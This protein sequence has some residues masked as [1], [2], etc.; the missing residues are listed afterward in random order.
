M[1]FARHAILALLLTSIVG[2]HTAWADPCG[3]LQNCDYEGWTGAAERV[4]H[5]ASQ[6]TIKL[7]SDTAANGDCVQRVAVGG[8]E[9][10]NFEQC[11][12]DAAAYT[13]FAVVSFVF[14]TLP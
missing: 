11:L 12:A 1:K 3:G 5:D 2:T 4:L 7:A 6:N 9:I 10:V 14:D 13:L 8:G